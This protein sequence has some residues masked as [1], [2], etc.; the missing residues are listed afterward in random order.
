MAQAQSYSGGCHCGA[1]SFRVTTDA[2]VVLEC[3][4]S[5]CRKKGFLHL[6]VEA[7]AFTMLEGEERLTS[8]GFGTHTARHLFCDTCGVQSYYH[9]RSHPN[10]ISINA[11]CLDDDALARFEVIPF[12]GEN[13]EANVALIRH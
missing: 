13:W 1:V 2:T 3:N 4:C 12:D 5:I 6:I 9:P 10:G 7:E 8:Y 11:R